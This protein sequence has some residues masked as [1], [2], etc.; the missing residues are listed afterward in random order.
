MTTIRV[1]KF[2]D[3][4]GPAVQEIIEAK[5]SSVQPRCIVR[6]RVPGTQVWLGPYPF[7]VD[8]G[9]TQPV[10][11][12]NL[13]EKM[14]ITPKFVGQVETTLADGSIA[15]CRKMIL[16]LWVVTNNPSSIDVLTSIE[17]LVVPEGSELLG[18]SALKFFHWVNTAAGFTILGPID[19]MFDRLENS[20]SKKF[21]SINNS[22]NPERPPVPKFNQQ[23]TPGPYRPGQNSP[24]LEPHE[25][26]G[27]SKPRPGAFLGPKKAV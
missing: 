11:T 23:K 15:K 4:A 27:A 17:I 2:E 26:P 3:I 22:S 12:E 1:K 20:E 25:G 5:N 21:Y 14:G 10:I 24:A 19:E 18:M 13:I 8:S 16:D 7:D 6:L 9:A